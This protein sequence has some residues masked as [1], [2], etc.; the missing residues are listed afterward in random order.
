MPFGC[1]FA[2]LSL[3]VFASA[4]LLKR[5]LQRAVGGRI[6]LEDSKTR[7]FEGQKSR[8]CL[9]PKSSS[10]R[11]QKPLRILFRIR[12]HESFPRFAVVSPGE[13]HS[14]D[15]QTNTLFFMQ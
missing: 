1:G 15:S 5:S 3:C 8:T 13:A 12:S 14:D 7:R 10:L 2:A 11:V 6:E 4:I 9:P